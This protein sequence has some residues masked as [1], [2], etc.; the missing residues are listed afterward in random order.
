M[1]AICLII[2]YW[3]SKPKMLSIEAH[4]KW[5]INGKPRFD[6]IWLNKTKCYTENKK[7]IKLSKMRAKKIF[8]D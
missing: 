7:A 8:T 5:V 4:H 2:L 1:A 6:D 3:G